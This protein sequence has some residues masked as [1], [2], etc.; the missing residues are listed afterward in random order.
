[1]PGI[2]GKSALLLSL[3][4]GMSGAH[5]ARPSDTAPAELA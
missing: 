3:L 1:M 2:F 5:A 4:L